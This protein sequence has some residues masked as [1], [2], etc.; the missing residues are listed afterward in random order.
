MNIL[1]AGFTFSQSNLTI[2]EKC[3]RKFYLRDVQKL[4]WPA[5][6]TDKLDQWQQAI[7]NGQQFHHLMYQDDLGVDVSELV[8]HDEQLREWWRNFCLHPPKLPNGQ[9]FSEMELS[10]PFANYRLIA[11]Y[12]RL[13]FTKEKQVVIVDWKTGTKPKSIVNV[14]NN[15]QT[16]IYCYVLV[17]GGHRLFPIEKIK[18]EHISFLYWYVNYPEETIQIEYNSD[19]HQHIKQELAVIIQKITSHT[20][21]EEFVK[22]GNFD[23]CAE[24]QYR[25]YCERGRTPSEIFEVDEDM[26][27]LDLNVIAA[28]DF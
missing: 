24:C 23:L 14:A 10:I 4:E 8:E 18:P 15:W 12:D 27:D 2:Y 13:I 5:P 9:T 11:K 6:L 17:E 28:I 21:S 20:Q 19:H 26:I 16:K 3:P 1:P 22:T 7:K 25:S